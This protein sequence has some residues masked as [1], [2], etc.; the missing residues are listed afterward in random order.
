MPVVDSDSLPVEPS[1]FEWPELFFVAETFIPQSRHFHRPSLLKKAVLQ[2]YKANNGREE[3][4]ESLRMLL[5][6]IDCQIFITV[7]NSNEYF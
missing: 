5:L 6:L 3:A 7:S 2:Q 4:E 1:P